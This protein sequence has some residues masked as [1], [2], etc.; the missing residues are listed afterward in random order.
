MA[1][2]WKWPQR[3]SSSKPYAMGCA[4]VSPIIKICDT[5]ERCLGVKNY[6]TVR[7]S[8]NLLL[9]EE[10]H[11]VQQSCCS[12]IHVFPRVYWRYSLPILLLSAPT[13]VC[14]RDRR[15]QSLW[16]LSQLTVRSLF[17]RA[18]LSD[19]ILPW[20]LRGTLGSLSSLVNKEDNAGTQNTW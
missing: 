4:S 2:G 7:S 10:K 1:L 6:L 11:S 5:W 14:R 18:P 20:H 17:A 16:M 13:D 9:Q 12:Q 15:W 3:S 19:I 8:W